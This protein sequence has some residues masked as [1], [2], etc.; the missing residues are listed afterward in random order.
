M[1]QIL[2]HR[3]YFLKALNFM[4]EINGVYKTGL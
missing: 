4:V 2:S 3:W 1:I